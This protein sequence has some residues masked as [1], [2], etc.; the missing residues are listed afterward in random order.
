MQE[1]SLSGLAL[2]KQSSESFSGILGIVLFRL[3]SI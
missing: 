1:K 2:T 3:D